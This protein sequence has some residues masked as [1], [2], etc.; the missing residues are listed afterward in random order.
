MLGEPQTMQIHEPVYRDVVTEVREFFEER[1]RTLTSEGIAV[2]RICLDPG[3]GF[4]K[5]VIDHNYALLAH[6]AET[7]PSNLRVPLLAGMSRKSMLGAVTGRTQPAE[8]V[9]A[10]VAAAVC[11]AQRG[12]AIVR[13]HDVA[14]TSDALKVWQAV[15]A[16]GNATH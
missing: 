6:F 5:S 16:A 7:R 10:S 2:E 12:A 11:A 4:G 1:V 8:R 14:A 9:A 15:R 13:V 3:F